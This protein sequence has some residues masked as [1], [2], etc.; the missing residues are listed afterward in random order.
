MFKKIA[1]ALLFLFSAAAAQAAPAFT[2]ETGIRIDSATVH[3]VVPII[4]GYRMFYSSCST[5][6]I[7]IMSSTSTDGLSWTQES[8]VRISTQAGWYDSSS[9]TAFGYLSNAS[10]TPPFRAYYVGRSASVYTVLSATSTDGFNFGK[11]STFA[12]SPGSGARVYSLAPVRI[13]GSNIRL[14]YTRDTGGSGNLG[15]SRLYTMVSNDSGQTFSGETALLSGTTVYSVAASVLSDSRIRLY[16]ATP[17]SGG[18]TGAQVLSAIGPSAG[19]NFALETGVRLSTTPAT[20][21]LRSVAVANAP[22]DFRWRMYVNKSSAAYGDT[23]AYS[24]LTLTPCLYSM[25]PSSVYTSDDSSVTFTVAGEIFSSTAPTLSFSGPGSLALWGTTRNSDL[26]MTFVSNGYNAALGQY[27]LLLTNYDGNTASL[28]KALTVDFKP[29]SVTMLDN[30]FRPMS[31]GRARFDVTVNMAG[32][33]KIKVYT[34]NGALVKTVYDGPAPSGL[35]YY[36]WNGDTEAGNK[37]ASGLYF[38]VVKGPKLESVQKVVL[39]K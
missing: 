2:E 24:A 10:V 35:S 1:A 22:E 16:L 25:S 38:A 34:T 17:L 12:L 3:A 23:K 27:D 11:V 4:N 6:N 39:I 20:V 9:I 5:S 30:L 32:N 36:Y 8:G 18:T 33:V 29:G 15:D 31:G 28:S 7:H 26:S 37:A 14:Y 19:T 13:T 21:F